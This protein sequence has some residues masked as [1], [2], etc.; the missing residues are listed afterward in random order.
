LA[1]YIHWNDRQSLDQ[2]MMVCLDNKVDL[3]EVERW[4]IQEG[5]SDKY[6]RFMKLISEKR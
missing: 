4:S 2:A 1:A 6:M 3:K 5:M